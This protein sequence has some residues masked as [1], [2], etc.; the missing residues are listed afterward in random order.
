MIPQYVAGYSSCVG[1]IAALQSQE[2]GLGQAV[3]L[4]REDS[5]KVN[6]GRTQAAF[7]SYWGTEG[8][9]PDATPQEYRSRGCRK[10]GS[11]SPLASLHLQRLVRQ[12]QK[13]SYM[14]MNPPFRWSRPTPAN[15][16]KMI[17]R[18][19]GRWPAPALFLSGMQP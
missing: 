19:A 6:Q 13:K 17:G 5:D 9:F 2:G 4:L 16:S 7:T 8:M 14:L 1:G 11:F 18:D 12:R 3:C 15:T 10:A